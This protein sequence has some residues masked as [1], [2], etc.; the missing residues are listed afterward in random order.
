MGIEMPEKWG[1]TGSTF[2]ASLLVIEEMA[3]VDPSIAVLCDIHNTLI[4]TSLLKFASPELQEKYCPRVAQD[5][6][7]SFC[8]SETSSGSDAFALKTRAVKD[9][10]HYILNGSKSWISNSAEAGVFLVFA[11]ANPEAGYRGITC[12][13][14][15]RDTPGFT[16]GR[17]EDKVRDEKTHFL[18]VGLCRASMFY[19]RNY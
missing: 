1:G 6:V 10:D 9:G 2:F 3:K 18:S 5:T 8:L 11:N 12:F 14:V 16:I 17:K 19:S 13:L 7:G 4:V 15:E